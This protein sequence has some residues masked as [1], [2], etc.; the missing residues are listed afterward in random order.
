MKTNYK[1]LLKNGLKNLPSYSPPD[2]CWA[3]IEKVLD[4]EAQIADKIKSMPTHE[5][6]S[7]AWSDISNKIWHKKPTRK[8]QYYWLSAAASVLILISVILWYPQQDRGLIVE[9]EIIETP[10]QQNFNNLTDENDPINEIKNLC[11]SGASI[12]KSEEFVQKIELYDEL[13]AELM[14]LQKAIAQLGESPE[15]IQSIIKIENLK[16]E[17]IQELIMLIHS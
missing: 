12:C 8:W 16:S 15:M 9:T 13:N 10:T 3:S 4:F 6:K 1:H 11:N 14:Q 5:P 7:L 17:T 2:D